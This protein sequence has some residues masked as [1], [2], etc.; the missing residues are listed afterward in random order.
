MP[1]Y[2]FDVPGPIL[3]DAQGQPRQKVTRYTINMSNPV[4]QIIE[5]AKKQSMWSGLASGVC[6]A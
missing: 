1:E 5:D 2:I 4:C 6:L 3:Y